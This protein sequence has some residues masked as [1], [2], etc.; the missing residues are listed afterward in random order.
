MESF[1]HA[2]VREPGPNFAQG[3][4][5]AGLGA[6][7]FNKALFQHRK[8]CEALESFGISLIR[9]S[10]DLKYPDGCFVEDTAVIVG[11]HAVITRPGHPSRLG[12]QAATEQALAE[13]KKISHIVEPGTLDGGDVLY[14]DGH[15][16]I[17]LSQR[18]NK[19][20]AAQLA[21]I[22]KSQKM[23]FT[24]LP[25]YR[26]LHLKSGV[27]S[28][29]ADSI[30]CVPELIHAEAFEL[31]SL[32]IE[33]SKAERHAANCLL[34]NNTVLMPSNCPELRERIERSGKKVVVLDMSEFEKMDGGLS[35]L[36]IRF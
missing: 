16:Y 24:T 29:G 15:F 13:H 30:V 19:E 6:P 27:T 9:L 31:F 7:D 34:I 3:I 36:S 28:I 23:S 21:E 4:T 20:G 18:T 10:A 2:I 22:V 25:V 1:K 35:C 33:V 32:K 14:M 26:L 17:G 5:V 11:D 8:Y 12:E